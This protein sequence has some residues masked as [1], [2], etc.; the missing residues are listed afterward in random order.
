MKKVF[1]YLYPIEEYQR[2][3]MCSDKYYE[4]HDLEN[5]IIVIN[6]C[7]KKRYKD[8]GYEV[9]IDNYPD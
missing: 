4:N 6:E 9:I 1:L 7:I 5:P 8:N 3:L 2:V